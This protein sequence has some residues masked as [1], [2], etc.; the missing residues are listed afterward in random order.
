M[1]EKLTIIL[2]A[3]GKGLRL[4]LPYS[5]EILMLKSTMALI[6]YSF[7]LFNNVDKELIKFVIIINEK[8][9]DIIKYL[10]KYK[11]RFNIS[12]TY[13]DPEKPEYTGAIKSS[14]HLLGKK[15]LVLLPDTKLKLSKN[16]NLFKEVINKLEKEDFT[17]LFKY[18]KNF[19]VLK[20]KGCIQLN[21]DKKVVFYEDKPKSGFEIFD[22]YWGGFAFNKN[23]FFE[24][25]NFMEKST[26]KKSLNS[27]AIQKT[28]IYNSSVIEI[29]DY[30]DLGSWESIK[31]YMQN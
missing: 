13:Q 20:T 12:F 25:L 8:K 10:S 22:G 18:E 23:I 4:N 21:E 15:N 29:E 24:S 14:Y 30:L 28:K 19:E 1:C 16:K 9:T 17:F 7:N 26:L 27:N 5:K 31:Y 11:C 2:P 6:D 3:A